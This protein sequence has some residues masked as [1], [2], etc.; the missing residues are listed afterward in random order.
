MAILVAC[1]QQKDRDE[2][3]R[4][5]KQY[6][7]T[8]FDG[9]V[10]EKVLAGVA[11]HLPERYGPDHY[12][13]ELHV[14]SDEHAITAVLN[15]CDYPG[16][17]YTSVLAA[18]RGIAA[19]SLDAILTCQHKYYA[20]IAQQKYVPEATPRFAIVSKEYRSE[21]EKLPFPLFI[22]PVKSYL[23]A[24]ARPLNT[25]DD[26]NYYL[27]NV[28]IPEQFLIP[29][30]WA[31][32]NYTDYVFDGSYF[33]AEELLRGRQ[34]TL[35]GYVFEGQV[36]LIGIVDSVML[37]GTISFERF[38]YPS[39]L[40]MH[41]QEKMFSIAQ[42]FVTGIGLDMS[43]FNIEFMYDDTTDT[44]S[45]IEINPRMAAQFCDLFEMVNGVS[46]YDIL[47]AIV[48]GKKPIVHTNGAF[49]VA[50]SL[51]CR[52]LQDQRVMHAPTQQEIQAAQTRFPELRFYP[53]ISAGDKL[54]DVLQDGTSFVYCWI[55]LGARN[56][57][58]LDEKY[59]ESK[60]LL[61]FVFEGCY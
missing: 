3:I 11:Q 19:P 38:V 59:Q 8:D 33:I 15:T 25:I 57:Q 16:C 9:S 18:E 55:H 14:L 26:L 44:V 23:S 36:G 22:K 6:I 61:P 30:N 35:E 40:P 29:F 10:F 43:L 32:K 58:E 13:K 49:Q 39:S 28:T 50:A 45:I 17:I 7:F 53:W 2:L 4:A 12:L 1:A 5:D 37:P 42:R 31:V 60:L 54:S 34:V 51:V 20:R 41:V 46:N 21:V 24:L 56:R 47:H 52:Q 27:E 48:N